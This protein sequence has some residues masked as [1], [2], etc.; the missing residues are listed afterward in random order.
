MLLFN[1]FDFKICFRPFE[2]RAP[3]LLG[4][5][6][7][8]SREGQ[9]Q[10]LSKATTFSLMAQCFTSSDCDSNVSVTGP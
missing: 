8:N 10:S 5:E 9:L 6:K 4:G 1:K 2:K 7:G 3:G